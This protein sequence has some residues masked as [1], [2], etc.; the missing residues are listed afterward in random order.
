[1]AQPGTV[2]R[3]AD[4]GGNLANPSEGL[5]DTGWQDGDQPAAKHVNADL[6]LIGQW[7]SYLAGL[8]NNESLT[9]ILS[10]VFRDV[11][12]GNGLTANGQAAITPRLNVSAV[13]I[14]GY[15]AIGKFKD[16]ILWI[17]AVSTSPLVITVN[18]T[19]EISGT[20][21]TG[22]WSKITNGAQALAL[23]L[24]RDRFQ[25]G[26][27]PSAQNTAWSDAFVNGEGSTSGWGRSLDFP[28]DSEADSTSQADAPRI[29][30]QLSTTVG[31]E[32][33]C[34][35]DFRHATIGNTR[36]YALL[37]NNDGDAGGIE[38]SINAA[39]SNASN[40]WTQDV[41]ADSCKYVLSR[42]GFRVYFRDSSVASPFTDAA[43]TSAPVNLS[44]LTGT[45][46]SEDAS[47][48]TL[49]NGK[50][51][52]VGTQTGNALDANPPFSSAVAAN[53]LHAKNIAKAW[54]DVF[55]DTA[56]VTVDEGYN[57][58]SATK[59]NS[60]DTVSI[61]FATPMADA[62]YIVALTA[63]DGSGST[64]VFW[65]AV[66]RNV[67]GFVL[68]GTK[69]TVTSNSIARFDVGNDTGSFG[70]VVFG[71]QNS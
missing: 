15:T 9:W 3:W 48:F 50:I 58:G 41:S 38:I 62:N 22:N 4:V 26:N 45:L 55:V 1:M 56:S 69:L 67:N 39:W 43:W 52:F 66:S 34:I 71:K 49:G 21:Q 8:A 33:V 2:F 65:E 16:A 25:L 40:N 12:L 59:D 31:V 60:A 42:T 70:F 7:V 35:L 44:F 27:M 23:Y 51:S 61:G 46:A 64:S 11:T 63:M 17:G 10:Q 47:N 68:R 28:M 19:R 54:G 57:V 29:A 5:K 6:N 30:Q 36:V 24:G 53:T 13:G 37:A 32:R 20:S 14:S 18:A